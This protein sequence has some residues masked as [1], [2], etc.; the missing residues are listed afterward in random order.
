M[1]TTATTAV[2]LT[3]LATFFWGSNFQATK[4]ALESVPPWTASVERFIIAVIGIFAI[5]IVKEGLRLS[6]LSRNFVAYVLLGV[7]GVA[8]FNGSLFVGL[9]TSS[10][11]TA[12]LIMATTPISANILEALLNRKWPAL[13]RIIGMAISLIG[14]SLVIT[15]GRILSG[16]IEFAV[17]DLIIL[18]GSIGWAAYTVGTRAFIKNSTPLETTSW[19]MFFGSLALIVCAFLL[20]TPFQAAAQTSG[21]SL[22]AALWMGIAG[23]VL[24]YLFWNVGIAVRGPGKTSIFFNFVPVFALLISALLGTIP[25]LAQVLGIVLT[26]CGVLVGQGRL[27]GLFRTR[28]IIAE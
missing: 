9:Q 8:G 26:I 15:N 23:S 1:K 21:I 12:S 10:P 25:H 13:D 20:E 11:I 7:I 5:L 18:M 19:T 6:T 3:L 22:A 27:Y 28:S 4:F 14:V 17:G 2:M 16:Q 24:A